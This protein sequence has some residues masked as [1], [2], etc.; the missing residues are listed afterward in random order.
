MY[1]DGVC[2]HYRAASM[3]LAVFAISLHKLVFPR[4][5]HSSSLNDLF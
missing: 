5:L 2:K 1:V 4:T 3:W